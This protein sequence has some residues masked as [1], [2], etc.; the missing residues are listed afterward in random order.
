MVL[1]EQPV[2]RICAGAICGLE[3]CPGGEIE[4]QR[5]ATILT[6]AT[7]TPCYIRNVIWQTRPPMGSP[8]RKSR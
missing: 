1:V 6:V 5:S 3:Q 7:G 2:F 8:P 4:I